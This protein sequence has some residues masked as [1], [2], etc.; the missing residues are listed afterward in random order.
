MACRNILLRRGAPFL[1]AK[2]SEKAQNFYKDVASRI[3]GFSL[4]RIES[5]NPVNYRLQSS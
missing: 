2:L 3:K 4:Q 1:L 5:T